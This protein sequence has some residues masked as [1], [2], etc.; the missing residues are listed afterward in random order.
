M[1]ANVTPITDTIGVEI[2]GIEGSRLADAQAAARCR[3][4]LDM[5]GVVVFRD[6]HIADADLVALSRMLGD[7]VV[8]PVGGQ[9][10]HPEISAISLDPAT[11][12]LA[13]YN[14][15][16]FHWHIDGATDAV[17]QK[18]TLLTALEVS[19]EGG[20]TEFANTY[21]GYEALTEDEKASLADLRVVHS[22]AAAQLLANPDPSDKQRAAWA[23]VPTREHPL[24][25]TRRNGRKSLLLGATAAHVVGWPEEQGRALLDRLLDWST[26]PR[27]SLRHHWRRGD[28]VLW[29]NTGM[30]H[31]AV[32]YAPTSPRLLHRTTLIGEEAVA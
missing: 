28:L 5:H 31:R 17:P 20:D 8:A 2:T 14:K 6:A 24:I 10:K 30:L 22:F 13:S 9:E 19:E 4:L 27:F 32:P 12:V 26:Q 18:S 23:R 1:F 25:W 3:A 15:G 16:T 29:D 21:A 7:V 11:T